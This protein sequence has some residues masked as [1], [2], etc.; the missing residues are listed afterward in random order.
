MMR[1]ILVIAVLG[2]AGAALAQEVP[3]AAATCVACHGDKG[4]KPILPDYPI[5]AGQYANYLE[6]ALHEYKAGKRKNPVMS[7]Q[8]AQLSPHDIEELAE[9]FSLQE[10]PLYVPRIV[11]AEKK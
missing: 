2:F 7:A 1:S 11:A 4:A 8:A 5:L 6:H 10:S 3:K 9:Y